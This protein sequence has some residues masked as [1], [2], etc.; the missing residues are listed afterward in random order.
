MGNVD[1]KRADG[2]PA[3]HGT[4]RPYAKPTL[5]E[6]GSVAKLT[7]SAGSTAIEAGS[8]KM[9]KGATCL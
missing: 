9:K 5:L 8:P 4:R 2:G 3:Q 1:D 6:Y 7:Q